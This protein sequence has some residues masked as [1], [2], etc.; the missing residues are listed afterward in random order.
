MSLIDSES[1]SS[2]L[3][4]DEKEKE[5][6]QRLA[7]LI[8]HR[9]REN[10]RIHLAYRQKFRDLGWGAEAKTYDGSIY[11]NMHTFTFPNDE[12]RANQEEVN[13]ITKQ[14]E[15]LFPFKFADINIQEAISSIIKWLQVQEAPKLECL[16]S[17]VV[18]EQDEKTA[19][20]TMLIELFS[21]H[22]DTRLQ[23]L[24]DFVKRPENTNTISV[25]I[26]RLITCAL[27]VPLPD[28]S[29]HSPL[30]GII[31]LIND[32][33]RT[34]SSMFLCDYVLLCLTDESL[35][36]KLLESELFVAENTADDTLN[37][38]LFTRLESLPFMGPVARKERS[39]FSSFKSAFSIPL[40]A[41]ETT[42]KA[43]DS[44]QTQVLKSEADKTYQE[45]NNIIATR[46][47]SKAYKITDMIPELVFEDTNDVKS[48]PLLVNNGQER[49]NSDTVPEDDVNE[50]PD[51]NDETTQ[52][53]DELHIP[54]PP[55]QQADNDYYN[56]L[57]GI[58][59]KRKA[60]VTPPRP[61]YSGRITPSKLR[62]FP[63]SQDTFPFAMKR[64]RKNRS[65]YSKKW[66]SSPYTSSQSPIYENEA[67]LPNFVPRVPP[68]FARP[69]ADRKTAD[70]KPADPP[71]EPEKEQDPNPIQSLGGLISEDDDFFANPPDFVPAVPVVDTTATPA[72][73]EVNPPA[74][75]V[76]KGQDPNDVPRFHSPIIEDDADFAAHVPKLYPAVP[77]F[78]M[79][80][81]DAQE[82]EVMVNRPAADLENAQDPQ[83]SSAN[84]PNFVP[85]VVD[86]TT[87]ARP[88]AQEPTV[89]RPAAD[90]VQDSNPMSPP[91]SLLYG[92][93]S[94]VPSLINLDDSI[95]QPQE[96]K[97]IH[98]EYLKECSEVNLYNIQQMHFNLVAAR[99]EYEALMQDDKIQLYNNMHLLYSQGIGGPIVV[100]FLTYIQTAYTSFAHHLEK[101]ETAIVRYEEQIMLNQVLYILKFYYVRSKEVLRRL[102]GFPKLTEDMVLQNRPVM[103]ETVKM[104]RSLKTVFDCYQHNTTFFHDSVQDQKMLTAMNSLVND[105]YKLF[106]EFNQAYEHIWCISMTPALHMLVLPKTLN[107]SQDDGSHMYRT[108]IEIIHTED[109]AL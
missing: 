25:A 27:D 73:Q 105:C 7:D 4:A 5:K 23:K 20:K 39:Y 85:A 11:A 1:V 107:L 38:S 33:L 28:Y 66:S 41:S 51:M 29:E 79:P 82:P 13:E 67:S 92:M 56:K 47:L 74:V 55:Y 24:L 106:E 40:N 53:L 21:C 89:N 42:A 100:K 49:V 61:P 68:S 30:S 46:L 45:L 63:S 2:E 101:T 16:D 90:S 87:D 35:T 54:T 8:L 58:E 64:P 52:D 70:E 48:S 43:Y 15:T 36:T 10:R 44:F 31:D 75:D 83:D 84:P 86:M 91:A 99:A 32:S 71:Q 12:D 108:R 9:H 93:S 3:P 19:C 80:T 98:N 72:A 50:Q 103:Q 18:K 22:R 14:Q 97:E 81:T 26:T 104:A 76:E 57:L 34:S 62:S 78:D 69:F 65:V 17:P 37:R 77:V 94:G 109:K 6:R 60:E 59:T 95:P 102:K 88:A 96:K